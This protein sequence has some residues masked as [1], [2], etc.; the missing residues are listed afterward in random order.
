M[1]P[2][3]RFRIVTFNT[4]ASDFT[5][6]FIQATPDKVRDQIERIKQIQ[7]TA[8]QRSSMDSIWRINCSIPTAQRVSSW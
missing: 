5:G 1:S 7:A 6:G 2:N 3:D 8:A 4:H